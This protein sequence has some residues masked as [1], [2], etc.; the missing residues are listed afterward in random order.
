MKVMEMQEQFPEFA[1]VRGDAR[2]SG[3]WTARW[4]A[5]SVQRQGRSTAVLADMGAALQDIWNQPLVRRDDGAIAII[6]EM[7]S[8]QSMDDV[9]DCIDRLAARLRDGPRRRG[10]VRRRPGGARTFL[11]L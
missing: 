10:R 1:G 2:A 3:E 5:Q 9:L 4:L 8:A 11:R 6:T 7:V